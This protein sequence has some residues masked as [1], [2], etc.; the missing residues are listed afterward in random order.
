MKTGYRHLIFSAMV[1]SLVGAGLIMAGCS[2]PSP[3]SSTPSASP[4]PSASAIAPAIDSATAAPP[5]GGR[6]PFG[7]GQGAVGTI[8]NIQGN[9]LAVNT[10]QGGQITVNIAQN[11]SIQMDVKGSISDLQTGQF[12]TVAGTSDSNGN[13]TASSIIL[14]PQFAGA[15][16]IP[17]VG[18]NF[19]A[20]TVFPSGTRPARPDSGNNPGFLSR[21]TAGTLASINGNTLVLTAGQG[22][23]TV[24]VNAA[25]LIQ[26]TLTGTISDLQAGETITAVGARDASGNVNAL[27]IN[28]RSQELGSPAS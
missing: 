4:S 7:Q 21:G 5:S 6:Q 28:V 23:V 16:R 18:T 24:Y 25:T 11:T 15:S 22:Q 17:P 2:S 12:L 26:K 14:R 19:P 3:S 13:V 20:G 9:T 27:S 1:L 8:A 10:L